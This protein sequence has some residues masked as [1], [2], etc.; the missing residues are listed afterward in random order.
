MILNPN[1]T[2]TNINQI[3]INGNSPR[4]TGSY[5]FDIPGRVGFNGTK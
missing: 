2:Y 1:S 3:Y 5:L 4:Y